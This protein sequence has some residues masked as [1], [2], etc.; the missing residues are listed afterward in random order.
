MNIT[1]TFYA[2]TRS[3]WRTWLKSH[4]KTAKDIW[5][6]YYKKDSGRPRIS[7][8]DAV[9]EA[10]CF[11][12]IDSTV[13]SLDKDRYAQRFSPRN[14]NTPYSQSNKVRLAKLVGEK[15]VHK[16]V[17]KTL[18]NIG[19]VEFTIPPDILNAIKA[20]KAAWA[21][22]RKYS[23]TYKGIRTAFIEGTR[24]RPKEFEKRLR[25][26]VKMTAAGKQIGFGGIKK[27]F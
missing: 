14:P 4:F 13:K 24:N 12:W 16:D 21:N 26:F 10:L 25:Y 7:Y 2:P 17:L 18:G 27:Y 3:A 1:H 22:F 5:L 11:G 6:V 9:E 20:N 15:R 23:Q 8:N 19:V